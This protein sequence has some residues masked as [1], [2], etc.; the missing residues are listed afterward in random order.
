MRR[1]S[2][3]K[4]EYKPIKY[5]QEIDDIFF[6]RQKKNVPLLF[7][8]SRRTVL[9]LFLF[10]SV[11]LILYAIGN[12]QNFLDENMRIVIEAA[13]AS[14]FLLFFFTLVTIGE[15]VFL[16]VRKKSRKSSHYILQIVLLFILMIF[17]VMILVSFSFINVLSVGV[18][19]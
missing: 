1:T 19:K 11:L 13:L 15:A 6:D 5:F 4:D 14:S 10:V 7:K 2:R 9:F 18:A 3:K 17:S 8:L 16:L 12:Y